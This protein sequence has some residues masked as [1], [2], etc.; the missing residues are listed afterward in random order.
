MA[1]KAETEI[2][3]VR[4]THP[5]RV[6]FPGQGL[7]KRDLALYL[8]AAAPRMLPHLRGR[9]LSLVRCPQGSEKQCFFQRHG[10]SGVPDA[11]GRFDVREKDGSIDD[12]L[13]VSD[14]AGL[15]ALAQIGVLEFHIWG[16]RIDAIEKPDRLVFDLD[17]DPS[18]PFGEVRKAATE[19]RDALDAAG[20]ASFP[21]LTGGKGIHVV[22]PLTRRHEWPVVKDFAKALA[23]RFA[24]REPD[25]YVA[26]ASKAKRE[27]RI[28]IDWLRNE[29]SASAIAPYSPRAREGAPVAWPVSWEAL[30]DVAS[31]QLVSVA[32]APGHLKKDDAWQGYFDLGQSLTAKALRA[33]GVEA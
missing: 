28:F 24:E 20:L 15:V 19:M 5:G 13:H 1:D 22:V 2:A 4:L 3:G 14:V 21:L 27:G 7:T 30:G 16:S 26:T 11:V 17:P 18:V 9:L 31:A 23:T 33:L 32:T 12:Y 25:R 10:G 6:L 29:R 8:E